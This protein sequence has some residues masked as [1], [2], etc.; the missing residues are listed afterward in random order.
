MTDEKMAAELRDVHN[1]L[2][3]KTDR[4]KRQDAR[5]AELESDH[6]ESEKA[7]I[8][9]LYIAWDQRDAYAAAMEQAK[10]EAEDMGDDAVLAL[11]E[12]VD[13]TDVLRDR[14]ARKWD[15]GF[16]SGHF[17]PEEIEE[18][19]TDCKCPVNPYRGEA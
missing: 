3:E 10:V 18:G 2:A 7:L 16:V 4:L 9:A 14:D 11:L 6:T 19:F 12:S 13:T 17:T 8:D 5:I 15:E 1:E